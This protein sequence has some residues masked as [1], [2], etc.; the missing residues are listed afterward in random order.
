MAIE[1]HKP[2]NIKDHPLGYQYFIDREHPLAHKGNGVV[3]YHRHL[4]S[5]REG[6]W[7]EKSEHIHHKDGN[8]SNNSLDNLEL[9]SNTQHGLTHHGIPNKPCCVCGKSFKPDNSKR[10]C[11]SRSCADLKRRK[12]NPSKEALAEIIWKMPMTKAAKL[13]DVS[14]KAIKRRCD[15]LNIALPPH[16]YWNNH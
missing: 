2:I 4:V 16:G 5:L 3:Y 15:L 7:L 6:R 13:F 12:F 14:D 10:T 11:C 8:R 9:T 1:Y